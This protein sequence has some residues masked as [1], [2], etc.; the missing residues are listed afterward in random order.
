MPDNQNLPESKEQDEKD[1]SF[2]FGWW[3]NRKNGCLPLLALLFL[4][5]LGAGLYYFKPWETPQVPTADQPGTEQETTDVGE[6]AATEPQKEESG[7]KEDPTEEPE[8]E[9]P[10]TA[11]P[12]DPTEKPTQPETPTHTHTWVHHDAVTHTVHHDAVTHTVHHDA[13]YKTIHHDAET[14]QKYVVDQPAVYQDTYYCSCG[15]STTDRSEMTA[16][17]KNAPWDEDHSEGV[18]TTLVQEEVGHY[19]TV[20]VKD[21]WDE[22]VVDQ[23]A[24]DETVVD[25]AA[26]DETVVDQAAYD[27]CSGCGARK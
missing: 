21:A 15:Y 1:R 27:E 10:E 8:T 7:K 11:K 18:R 3:N 19:E 24:W 4:L 14:T 22:T 13:T 16:H 17:M 5:I 2:L 23:A 6:G 25:Q 12:E 20:T 26:W 9:D